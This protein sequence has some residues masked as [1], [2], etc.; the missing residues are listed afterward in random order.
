MPLVHV[1]HERSLFWRRIPATYKEC[2]VGS[3]F[4]DGRVSHS[5]ESRPLHITTLSAE[6]GGD[7]HGKGDCSGDSLKTVI[8]CIGVV[9]VVE[10][11]IGF[12]P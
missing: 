7:D 11:E 1:K 5:T 9:T 10:E 8:G 4:G 12:H 2:H 3:D 6:D